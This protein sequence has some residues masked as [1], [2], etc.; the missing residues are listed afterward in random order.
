MDRFAE[1]ESNHTLTVF[2][3]RFSGGILDRHCQARR[4]DP[5]SW[6]TVYTS[7]I[8]VIRLQN[9]AQRLHGSEPLTTQ[10]TGFSAFLAEQTWRSEQFWRKYLARIAGIPQPNGKSLY[11][12][13]ASIS[14]YLCA[15]GQGA[16]PRYYAAVLWYHFHELAG[17]LIA[18][19]R[20]LINGNH[21]Y[22]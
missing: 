15:D 18:L 17:H 3:G 9:Q 10:Q 7:T 12:L 13:S 5:R 8:Q 16:L 14:M 11:S 21:I 2:I 1:Y 4:S 19:S 20:R 6:L 22:L